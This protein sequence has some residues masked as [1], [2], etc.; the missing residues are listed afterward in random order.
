MS[1]YEDDISFI[2]SNEAETAYEAVKAYELETA[3]WTND[4]VATDIDDVWEFVIK[5]AVAELVTNP[6]SEIWAELETVPDGRGSPEPVSTVKANVV[7]SPLVNVMVLLDTEAV[8]TLSKALEAVS[9]K[10]AWLDDIS[11]I[12]SNEAET[13]Y[14]AV[15]AYELE[16]A[17]WTNDAVWADNTDIDDV[18]EFVTKDA[19]AELVTN[20]NSEICDELEITPEGNG[21]SDYIKGW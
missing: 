17:F 15:K 13:A 6:N 10:F 11:F 21:V 3:F 2:I 1:A 5:D 14:E 9:A 12:I 4:A 19:V 20:P 16:T 18:W 7:L 8:S